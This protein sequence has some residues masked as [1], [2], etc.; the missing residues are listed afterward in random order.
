MKERAITLLLIVSLIGALG[1][2][3]NNA[4]YSYQIAVVDSLQIS[5]DESILAYNQWNMDSLKIIK[6]TMEGK[7]RE[8]TVLLKQVKD[9]IAKDDGIFLGSY[10]SAGNAFKSTIVNDRKF[11]KE[12][13]ITNLQLANLRNDLKNKS[14][15]EESIM[16]YLS[17]EKKAVTSLITGLDKTNKRYKLGTEQYK[18]M[19][20]RVDSLI[21]FLNSRNDLLIAK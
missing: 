11:K 4:D 16:S 14:L 2:C 3:K 5:L 17:D 15:S 7:L 9:T 20:P 18:K 19:T 21:S 8:M 1:S 13:D 12:I 6:G 10:K